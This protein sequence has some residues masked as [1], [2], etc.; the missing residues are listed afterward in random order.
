[1]A[2]LYKVTEWQS[3]SGSWWYSNDVS[4]LAGPS[5]KWWA[6]ARLLD[7]SLTDYILM[8]KNEFNAIVETY[9]SETDYLH[10]KWS[11]YADCHR[12]T[13]FINKKARDKNFMV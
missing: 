1:M 3:G 13:L 5:A 12:Y 11:N 4:D 2:H 9:N 8:L 6:A 7:M 10:V